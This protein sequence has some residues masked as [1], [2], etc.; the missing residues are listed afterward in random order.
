MRA[1]HAPPHPAECHNAA[2]AREAGRLHMTS[3][4]MDSLSL[5]SLSEFLRE[6]QAWAGVVL[7]AITFLESLVLIGA[8]VPA[9]A[10]M[11]LAGSLIAAGVIDPITV[12][13]WC[14]AGAIAGDA[15]SYA[16]GRRMGMRALH[17]PFLRPHRRKIARTR[18]FVRRYGS[19]SIFIGRF[20]G[21][22]RAFAPL[23]AGLL[24]MSHRKFQIA[25]LVSAF[26]WVPV[27]LAPGYLAA[28]WLVELENLIEAEG[29]TIV[30][31]V[32]AALVVLAIAAWRWVAQSGRVS[33]V[34]WP[35]WLSLRR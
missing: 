5:H 13:L 31:L 28:K 2:V 32:A 3:A 25:N 4:P 18:L 33:W 35:S 23:A 30:L 8:F 24:R 1:G 17:H 7:G 34:V 10:L 9:T 26:V 19:A 6:H 16:I 27:M 20:F 22:L 14:S 11:V 29:A 15:V 21:P 12:I